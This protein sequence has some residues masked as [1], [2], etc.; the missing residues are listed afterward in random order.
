MSEVVSKHPSQGLRESDCQHSRVIEGGRSHVVDLPDVFGQVDQCFDVVSLNSVAFAIK[1]GTH[2]THARVKEGVPFLSAKNISSAGAIRWGEEDDR[3][4][5]SDYKLIH[6]TFQLE[7]R[8]L[9]LTVVGSLGRR[10]IYRG[11]RVTFQR[12]VAYVRLDTEKYSERFL[13]HWFGHPRF[14]RELVRRSNATAQ[15]GLYLGELAKV[16]V[17]NCSSQEQLHVARVLDTVD[18]T[19]RQTEAIIAK[20]KQV[21]QGL[22]CDLLTRGVDTSGNL[23][24]PQSEAPHLYKKS[25]LGWIPLQWD[26][27]PIRDVVT[28]FANGASI[29]ADE[30]RESGTPVIAKGDVTSAKYIDTSRRVQFVAP[31]LAASKYKGSMINRSFV[32]CSMRDLVPSAPTLGM[33]SLLDDDLDCLLAQGTTALCLDEDRFDPELFIEVTRLHWFRT[34]TRAL[35]VGSTQVHMRGRDYLSLEIPKPPI[36]E[37][38][39]IVGKI[40]AI[41]RAMHLQQRAVMTLNATKFGLMDDLLTGRVRVTPMLDAA[42]S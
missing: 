8:D 38:H 25:P 37:Q 10:A 5:E 27:P 33:A 28:E 24:A 29:R 11:E 31:K 15:A 9:L 36:E 4:T 23:R 19:I 18:T 22:L 3:I 1:D 14:Q 6:R 17:P 40:A 42:T 7:D 35:A 26:S 13:F 32:V 39:Q 41:D 2:G 12:S 21:K 16:L 34:K 30:F 20:L